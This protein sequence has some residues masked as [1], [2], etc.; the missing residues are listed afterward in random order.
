MEPSTPKDASENPKPS[1]SRSDASP[2]SSRASPPGLLISNKSLAPQATPSTTPTTAS[3]NITAYATAL[4]TSI[5][6]ALATAVA[7]QLRL[8][9]KAEGPSPSSSSASP[10]RRASREASN[11]ARPPLAPG[12]TSTEDEGSG[13][14]V[15]PPAQPK[16]APTGIVTVVSAQDGSDPERDLSFLKKIPRFEPLI[17][18][19]VDNSI[20]WTTIFAPSYAKRRDNPHTI[21]PIPFDRI[22]QRIRR[23]AK[24]CIDAVLVDQKLLGERVTS[25]DEYCAKLSNTISGRVYQARSNADALI[26]VNSIA[27]HADETKALLSKIAASLDKLDQF[28]APGERLDNLE[29][30]QRYP[31]IIKMRSKFSPGYAS[32]IP[33]SPH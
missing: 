3:T 26:K 13:G 11:A 22:C 24:T 6:T 17:K 15:V 32:S 30:K 16:S 8:P 29:N 4:G 7:D 1:A 31:A 33:S 5:S 12:G 20:N 10:M 2:P 18:A 21:D 23:H 28:L 19:T 25:M 14:S 27:K 9:T